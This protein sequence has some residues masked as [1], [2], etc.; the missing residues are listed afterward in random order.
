MAAPIKYVVQV[1]DPYELSWG[2]Y[3]FD[4]LEEAKAFSELHFG[5]EGWLDQTEIWDAWYADCDYGHAVDIMKAPY[6]PTDKSKRGI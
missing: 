4:S 6:N 2:P 5:A 3:V 1:R